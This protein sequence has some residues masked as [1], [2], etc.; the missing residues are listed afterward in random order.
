MVFKGYTYKPQNLQQVPQNVSVPPSAVCALSQG[1]LL[2]IAPWTGAQAACTLLGA[3]VCL[4]SASPPSHGSHDPWRTLCSPGRFSIK[5]KRPLWG[6]QGDWAGGSA[7]NLPRWRIQERVWERRPS[8][9][10]SLTLEVGAGSLGSGPNVAERLGLVRRRAPRGRQAALQVRSEGRPRGA[11][12]CDSCRAV[13]APSGVSCRAE[14]CTLGG[15]PRQRLG[16]RKALHRARVIFS[17]GRI[18]DRC[19]RCGST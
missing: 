6:Q 19:C 7:S 13:R 1:V 8:A 12:S 10:G 17:S 11:G 14:G 18:P 9:S 2:R 4:T 3:P 16:L 15:R 5:E